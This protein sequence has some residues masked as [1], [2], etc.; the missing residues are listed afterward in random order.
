M[1]LFDFVF[2]TV[3]DLEKSSKNRIVSFLGCILKLD[4]F[5]E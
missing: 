2:I 4:D 5:L 1:K 3:N